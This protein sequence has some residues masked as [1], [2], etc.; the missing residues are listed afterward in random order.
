[1]LQ[2]AI[3]SQSLVWWWGYQ[4]VERKSKHEPLSANFFPEE[5]QLRPVYRTQICISSSGFETD[6]V[7]RSDWLDANGKL[8]RLKRHRETS[9]PFLLQFGLEFKEGP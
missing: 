2:L 9:V 7:L 5:L 8:V 4:S 1:M 6:S 3:A